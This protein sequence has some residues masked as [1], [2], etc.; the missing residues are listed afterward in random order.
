VLDGRKKK[1][2]CAIIST[3]ESLLM[4]LF[5]INAVAGLESEPSRAYTDTKE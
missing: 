5:D 4:R 1:E 3:K 2:K